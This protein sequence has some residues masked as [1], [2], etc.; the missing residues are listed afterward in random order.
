VESR[1]GQLHRIRRLHLQMRE[2][3]KSA[4]VV[5]DHARIVSAIRTSD[6]E[7]ARAAMR[8]HLSGTLS[9]LDKLRERFPGCF[10]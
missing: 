5:A 6:V 8:V 7:N 2:E 3:S 4:E 1:S 9:R 10:A